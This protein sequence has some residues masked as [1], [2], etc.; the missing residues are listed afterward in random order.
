MPGKYEDTTKSGSPRLIPSIAK[1]L[2]NKDLPIP[3]SPLKMTPKLR[4]KV[5]NAANTF[6]TFAK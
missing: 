1:S 5:S 2:E 4:S 3:L 6:S